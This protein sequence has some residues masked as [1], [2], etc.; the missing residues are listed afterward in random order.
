MIQAPPGKAPYPISDFLKPSARD[1]SKIAIA[2]SEMVREAPCSIAVRVGLFFDGTNNNLL[3]D[4][5]GTRIGIPDARGTSTSIDRIPLTP[6]EFSHSNVARLFLSFPNNMPAGYF[7]FYIAGVG[8]PFA[9]IGEP[10]ESSEGKAFAKGG[11]PRIIWGILQAINAV[12]LSKSGK[13][14]LYDDKKVGTLALDYD[15]EVGRTVD[16][17][18]GSRTIVTNKTWFEKHLSKLQLALAATPKPTISSVTLDVFGFSR[19]AAEAAAFCHYFDDLLENGKLAGVTAKINFLGV[20]DTVASVGLSSSASATM[21]LPDALV[22]GHMS[23]A[24]RIL[25][26]LPGCVKQGLHCIAAHEQRMNFPVTVLEGGGDF[27]Q[28]YFPGVHSDVG[29]GYA[30]GDSG[31]G[32][33]G[34]GAMLSQIPLA[35]MFK[36]A[37]LA[38][39]PLTPFSEL[40][41]TIQDDFEV[42]AALAS[43]WD[44]YTEALGTEGRLPRKHMELFYRYRAARLNTLEEAASFKA[45]DPQSQQDLRDSNRML[46][47]DLK[48]LKARSARATASGEDYV[49]PLTVQEEQDTSQWQLMRLKNPTQLDS[50]EKW[51]LGIFI[52]P[53]PLPE[54]VMRFFDDYVHDSLACFYLAGEVTEFDRRVKVAQIMRS[55]NPESLEGFDKRVYDLAIKTESAV[56]KKKAGEALSPEEDKLAAQAEFGTPYPLMTDRDTADMR[57]TIILT[58]TSTRREGGGYFLRRGYYPHEGFIFFRRSKYELLLRQTPSAPQP[59]KVKQKDELVFE[60][61]WS[62]DVRGDLIANANAPKAIYSE[63]PAV[64]V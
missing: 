43:A 56:K 30:P 16:D 21:P 20:F 34:Q 25:K 63:E 15:K 32:R 10:T 28:V 55:K 40:D 13:T 18:Y 2:S 35:H 38:G 57:Q 27:R 49:P 37:R 58:Q 14:P 17:P 39:V 6:K 36:A 29:G 59:V 53:Q 62:K 33:G 45:A 50:W 47:G 54:E 31:R 41:A 60:A 48:A 19:G 22:D 1:Q 46:I 52:Q 44:A 5:Q 12:Y 23:W 51:A 24:E 3:R 26:P 61:V 4:R 8:T 7:P 9:E 64:V 11:Q 42:D